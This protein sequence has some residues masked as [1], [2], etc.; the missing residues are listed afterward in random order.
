MGGSF[1]V[2]GGLFSGFDCTLVYLRQ[3]ED[4]WNSIASAALTGGCLSARMGPNAAL[5]SAFFGGMI[6]VRSL[7]A[8]L[9]VAA[10]CQHVKRRGC[11]IGVTNSTGCQNWSPM[12]GGVQTGHQWSPG[13][14]LLPFSKA[15]R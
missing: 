7:C 6:L 1:A 9:A 8:V 10:V 4:P 2:W 3:K 12:V 5:R 13:K 14:G 15:V 11:K